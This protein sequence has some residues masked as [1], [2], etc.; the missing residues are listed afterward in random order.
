[1]NFQEP[2]RA[3]VVI[4]LAH[5]AQL[6]AA[7]TWSRNECREK[8]LGRGDASVDLHELVD[9][10]IA[11]DGHG[12]LDTAPVRPHQQSLVLG[13]QL[14]GRALCGTVTLQEQKTI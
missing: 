13:E 1:M 7:R 3:W 4:G 11:L 8:D 5:A 14:L 2:A 12:G 9:H 6:A 10:D